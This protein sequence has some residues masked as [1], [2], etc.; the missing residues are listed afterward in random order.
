MRSQ[1]NSILPPA[2]GECKHRSRISWHGVV[3]YERRADL[4]QGFLHPARALFF[5]RFLTPAAILNQPFCD[6][7]AAH[8]CLRE[9]SRASA[10]TAAD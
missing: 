4:L 1:V 6:F 2:T 8:R 3:C 9:T 7:V 10:L 5:D